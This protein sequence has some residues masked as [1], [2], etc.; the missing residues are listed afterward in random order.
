M[1]AS[2]TRRWPA[3]GGSLVLLGLSV[4]GWALGAALSQDHSAI[5]WTAQTSD[6]PRRLAPHLVLLA[7]GVTQGNT[8][9]LGTTSVPVPWQLQGER[10]GVADIPLMRHLG[11]DLGDTAAADQQ[12]IQW[13]AD[14]PETLF[15]WH[16]RGHRYIDIT[17]W[18]VQQGWQ[19][20]PTGDALQL[21]APIG[22]IVTSRRGRQ[23]WGD[24]LVLEVDRPVLWSLNET[25]NTFTVTLQA[26]PGAAFDPTVL[27]TGE[28]TVLRT[29]AVNTTAQTVTITG[30][31]AATA[32]P[33]VWSLTNPHRVVI[34]L[35]E[36]DVRPRDILWA[37]GLRWREGYVQA[38]NRSFPVHQLWLTLDESVTLRPIWPRPD[39]L[40]GTA[41]LATTAQRWGTVAAINAGFFNRNNQLPLGAVRSDDRWVSGPILNRGAIAWSDQGQ[42]AINRIFLALG[43]TLPQGRSLTIN[44]INSGYVQAGIGL[45]TPEWGA[46]YTPVLDN[47][48]IVTVNQDRVVQQVMAGAAGADV[49]AIPPTGYVL[50]IRADSAAAR[51]LP[52]GTALTLSSAVRPPEFEALPYGVGGGPVL[53]SGGQLV[54]NAKAEGF[55]DAFATQAAPRSAVGVTPEGELLLVAIHHSPGGRGPTLVETAQIMQQLGAQ[56]ALNLDGGSSSSLYLGGS[57]VNRHPATV[58]R[59]HSGIGVFLAPEEGP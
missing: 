59:V 19:F 44:H 24:R 9:T 17:D 3:L 50:A 53:V 45:Y 31:V 46:T 1:V 11:V 47:E 15:A 12:P 5:A 58:G 33:R 16:A 21:Q 25:A 52:P 28:G 37:P 7:T 55:S 4:M 20:Q 35:T 10:L 51:S 8:I 43:L 54:V 32:R 57:L 49:Y 39:Q 13:F 18:A 40:P 56:A 26:Q 36:A 42:T 22:T 30:T 14:Q 38:G 6:P 41:P 29:L 27:M 2:R 23:S 34:D 48:T